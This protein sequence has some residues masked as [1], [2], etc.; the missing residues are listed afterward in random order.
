MARNLEAFDRH[1]AEKRARRV[2]DE[3]PPVQDCRAT[4]FPRGVVP[5]ETLVEDVRFDENRGVR[6]NLRVV[7]NIRHD[8]IAAMLK[9]KQ[10]GLY[11]ARAAEHWQDDWEKAQLGSVKAMNPLKE[12][13]DGTPP[14]EDPIN[15]RQR[16]ALKELRRAD[17]ILGVQGA[18]VVRLVLAEHLTI[19]QVA[20]KYGDS[21]KIMKDRL[22]WL[23]RTCL[24]ELAKF[25]GLADKRLA[26]VEAP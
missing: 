3:P 15:D 24:D 23:L 2:K 6:W 12:A 4:G 19:E 18:I 16:S 13:V 10:I 9:R 1:K 14:R 21:S 25:Y 20:Q 5:A 26:K 17:A 7:R 8:P 22:G 11:Q